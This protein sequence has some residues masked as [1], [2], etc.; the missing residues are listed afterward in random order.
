MILVRE[1]SPGLQAIEVVANGEHPLKVAQMYRYLGKRAAQS[2]VVGRKTRTIQSVISMLEQHQVLPD[3]KQLCST[4]TPEYPRKRGGD[5]RHVSEII[6]Q[7]ETMHFGSDY[8][9]IDWDGH[10]TDEQFKPR[11]FSVFD[12]YEPSSF[13]HGLAKREQTP[14]CVVQHLVDIPDKLGRAPIALALGTYDTDGNFQHGLTVPD[15][16][17]Y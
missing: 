11:S 15:S 14:H 1:V 5:V 4:I 9:H 17:I 13:M 16:L 12:L 6:D 8:T 2:E 7:F 3:G 10:E